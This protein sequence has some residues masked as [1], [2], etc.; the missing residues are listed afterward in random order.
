LFEEVYGVY[1]FGIVGT[2]N[3][4]KSVENILNFPKKNKI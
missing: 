4:A 1:D 2:M 3:D